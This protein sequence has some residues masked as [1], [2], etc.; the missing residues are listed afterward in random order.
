MALKDIIAPEKEITFGE[1]KFTVGALDLTIVIALVTKRQEEVRALFDEAQ[2][3]G[4]VA[5]PDPLRIGLMLLQLAPDFV[6]VAIALAAGEPGTEAVV[7]KLPAP[8]QLEAVNT[9]IDLNFEA[10]GGVKKFGET[11]V[12]LVQKATAALEAAN[13]TP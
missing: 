12:A 10:Q 2:R 6:A 7:R 4:L 13:S 1:N 11:L 9:I 5:N 8:V 3:Q